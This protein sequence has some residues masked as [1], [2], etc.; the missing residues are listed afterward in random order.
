MG[1]RKAAVRHCKQKAKLK[2]YTWNFFLEDHLF[3]VN[4]LVMSKAL[5]SDGGEGVE[6]GGCN[7]IDQ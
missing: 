1:C 2:S 6:E 7:T 3:S 4:M 5:V